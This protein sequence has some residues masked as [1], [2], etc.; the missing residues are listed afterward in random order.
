M[1]NV[2]FT[3]CAENGGIYHYTLEDGKLFF[4]EKTALEYPMYAVISEDRTYILLREIDSNTGFGG[5]ISYAVDKDGKLYNPSEITSSKGIVPCHLTVCEQGIYVVNYLSGNIVKLPDKVV[6]HKGKGVHPTRQES[7]H[8]HF[9]TLSPDKKYLLCTDLGLDTVFVYDKELNFHASARVP[10]GS[11]CRHLAFSE[12]GQFLYCVNELSND[13]SVFS[14]QNGKLSLLKTYPAIPD[15]KGQSTAA[16]IRVKNK[17]LYISH[18]GA[19]CISRFRIDG[20]NLLFL[21]N[22][23]CG[24]KNPRDFDILDDYLFCT[25]EGGNITIMELVSGKP[26]QIKQV[27]EMEDPLCV[28]FY[29]G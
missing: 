4:K 22:T 9:V 25:N 15:F 24:G 17:Y 11:G 8:T 12:D 29:E 7:A 26:N 2:Y 21:E 19:D 6:T 13:V 20:E 16:A 1:K 3:S 10:E 23:P 28:S 18:R 27:I 14:Y 5:L